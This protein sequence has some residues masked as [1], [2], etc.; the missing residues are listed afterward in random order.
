MVKLCTANW[1]LKNVGRWV[2]TRGGP[3][4]KTRVNDGINLTL[5][6]TTNVEPKAT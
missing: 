3:I 6:C 1:D 5:H 2:I 4:S